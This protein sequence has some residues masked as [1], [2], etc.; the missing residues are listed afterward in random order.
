MVYSRQPITANF[1]YFLYL[2][3][4]VYLTNLIKLR[5]LTFFPTIFPSFISPLIYRPIGAPGSSR[6]RGRPFGGVPGIP[7]AGIGGPMVRATGAAIGGGGGASRQ[8]SLARPRSTRSMGTVDP[9]HLVGRRI[10][11]WYPNEDPENPW[12]E[13]FI[14]EYN[15]DTATHGILY[16]PNDPGK[17]ESM[18]TG[19]NIHTANPSE[20]VLGD[21]FELEN[22]YGSQ[23]RSER[24]SNVTI[25]PVA[26]V[27]APAKRRRSASINVP[28]TVPFPMAW[29]EMAVLEATSDD[30]RTML[31]M[32]EMREGQLEVA[33]ADAEMALKMGGD[34]EKRESLERQF[35]ELCK[36]ELKIMEEL[37]A[38]QNAE[39]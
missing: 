7:A 26:A 35:N 1:Q 36:Q 31:N 21:Y 28:R 10:W 16:D 27:A 33:I 32:L 9:H 30:L 17:Q 24:P 18:E 2:I 34:L 19:F 37:K 14:V 38:V 3:S 25:T 20:Y 5:F 6:P 23:R 29:L 11:R 12:V 15:P 4:I 8:G 13:G 39:Q 22:C